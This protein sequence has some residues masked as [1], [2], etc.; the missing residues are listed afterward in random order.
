MGRR[1]PLAA[2]ILAALAIGIPAWW[3][4]MF[5]V[6]GAREVFVPDRAW[7]TFHAF[8][9]PDLALAGACALLA[10]RLW[11]GVAAGSLAAAVVGAWA[12]ATVFTLAWTIEAAAPWG[13][14][15]LMLAGGAG[16]VVALGRDRVPPRA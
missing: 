4:A 12:Y 1:R 2:A 15:L 10:G 13:G 6:A 8:V 14:A 7:P 9:W 5:H 11:R 3:A 16:L